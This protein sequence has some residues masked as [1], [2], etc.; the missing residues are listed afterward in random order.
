MYESMSSDMSFPEPTL[1]Y[2]QSGPRKDNIGIEYYSPKPNGD[3]EVVLL[4]TSDEGKHWETLSARSGEIKKEKRLGM[5][6]YQYGVNSDFLRSRDGGNHW[7]H[8]QFNIGDR[9]KTSEGHTIESVRA[10]IRF[11]FSGVDPREATTI[12]GCLEPKEVQGNSRPIS[13]GGLFISYD[14][15]DNWSL[16]TDQV[17]SRRESEGCPLGISPSNP[18]IMIAHGLRG[19]VISR[20]SG[21][22]WALAEGM[23]EFEKPA[24]LKGYAENLAF[25]KGK[26][27][28]VAKEW[29]FEWTYPTV[30]Q[31]EFL[32]LDPQVAFVV[33]N[34]GVYK[35]S[36]G[37]QSWCLLD[38]G[39]HR[40]S[41]VRSI[42]IESGAKP[43][44][45][46]GTNFK[47]LIS[48]DLGC[49]FKIFFD[50]ENYTKRDLMR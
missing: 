19:L 1:K 15:G 46:I 27:L 48:Y 11:I 30:T 37:G 21:K 12:Y 40:L 8:P 20:D 29:P 25:V 13:Y 16:L 10:D 49:H 50:W 7:E 39:P 14:A 33:T 24:K 6:V 41:D 9:R 43:R 5:F 32:P 4:N 45:F 26:G 18:D 42:Y 38:T 3:F 47:L 35:S 17:R 23:A 22:H 2:T 28:S 36:D 44:I 31:I 34:K